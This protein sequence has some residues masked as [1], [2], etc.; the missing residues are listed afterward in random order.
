MRV[1][2]PTL[3]L[4]SNVYG[5]AESGDDSGERWKSRQSS[6]GGSDMIVSRFWVV[7]V[8]V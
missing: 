4:N 7:R 3:G 2:D 5:G 6:T 8:T 1:S